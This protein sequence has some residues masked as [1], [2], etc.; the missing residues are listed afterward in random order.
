[1]NSYLMGCRYCAYEL[2]HA[3]ECPAY[4]P[5]EAKTRR[6]E[7]GGEV[8]YSGTEF[9]FDLFGQVDTRDPKYRAELAKVANETGYVRYKEAVDLAKKHQ[10]WDP[11]N[12]SKDFFRELLIAVQEKL[13]IDMDDPKDAVR[14][15]TAVGTPLDKYHGV[16]AF[17]AHR[18]RDGAEILVTLDATLRPEKQQEGWK[19]DIVVGAIPDVD[20]DEDAYLEAIEV[21][22]GRIA[23]NFRDRERPMAA[24]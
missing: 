23:D 20:E 13:E 3:K 22:A 14:A 24:E 7:K 17:L 10:P 1:M 12:P 21:I 16:D 11:T 19:A 18:A 4:D 8:R 15:Y 6:P 2:G 9:E 5:R